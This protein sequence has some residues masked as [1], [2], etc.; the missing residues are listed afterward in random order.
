M[1]LALQHLDYHPSTGHADTL[2][3][4]DEA[5]GRPLGVGLV[6]QWQMLGGGGVATLVGAAHVTGHPLAS[7]Q[8]LHG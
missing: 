7:V 1:A 6:G 2:A 3:P 4:G 5:L 8:N